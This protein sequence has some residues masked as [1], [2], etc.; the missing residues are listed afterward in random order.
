MNDTS[1]TAARMTLKLAGELQE[2]RNLWVK[3]LEAYFHQLESLVEGQWLDTADLKGVIQESQ[4]AAK[5]ALDGL[6]GD[7]S[8]VLV[9]E[10]GGLFARFE[11]ER[12]SLY[13]EI[14]TLRSELAQALS[15]D[16][17]TIRWENQSLRTALFKMPEFKLLRIVRDEGR[18][19][20]KEL[21]KKY[22][23]KV[24]EI[25]RL[26]KALERMGYVAIDKKSRPHT[27]VFLSAPWHKGDSVNAFVPPSSVTRQQ[28]SPAEHL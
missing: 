3:R 1:E 22:G 10:S 9:H 5:E 27:V 11:E 20:Y 28:E 24:S 21:S 25:R 15:R 18:V 13:D 14:T 19:A 8:A 7:L 6:G 2:I 26:V 12:R 16:E 4:Q 17:D 23:K